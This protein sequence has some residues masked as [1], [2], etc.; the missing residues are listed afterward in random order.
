MALAKV[1]PPQQ[2]T[3]AA[4]ALLGQIGGLTSMAG[5]NV[6]GLRGPTDLYVG[7]MNSRTVADRLIERLSLRVYFSTENMSVMRVRLEKA[8]KFVVGRDGIITISVELK[9]ADL[10]AKV[11]N[12]YVEELVRLTGLLAVTEA[13]Q[14]R[15]FFETQLKK[16]RDDLSAAEVLAQQSIN[17]NGLVAV[18]GQGRTL[19]EMSARLRAQIAAKEISI[20]AVRTFASDGNP[21]LLLAQNELS[22]LRRELLNLEEGR[23]LGR[24]MTENANAFNSFRLL[25][26][27]RYL[28]TLQDLLLKQTEAARLDEARESAV[29]QL[30]DEA[31]VPEMRSFPSRSVWALSAAMIMFFCS[32]LF[33]LA[34]NI[35]WSKLRRHHLITNEARGSRE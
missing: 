11:A 3:S 29:V 31:I 22:A 27:V 30:L 21:D 4:A 5:G 13:S 32:A 14:R 10:A 16:V 20:A 7:M 18:E 34:R 19:F 1:V 17:K 35:I 2:N 8:S 28:E 15:L 25:R 6:A 26:E 33:I 9:N 12:G 24:E 23:K